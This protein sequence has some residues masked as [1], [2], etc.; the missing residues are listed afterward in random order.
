KIVQ[1]ELKSWKIFFGNDMPENEFAKIKEFKPDILV[2]VDAVCFV[3]TNLNDKSNICE[4][5][6]LSDEVSYF[7][8]AHN[9][10]TSVWIKYLR[11]FVPKILFLGI[12]VEMSN[13]IQI[14]ENL[15]QKAKENARLAVEKIKILD[16]E[17]L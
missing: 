14:K 10:P 2:V 9:I 3:D 12:S 17:L 4:F 8:N 6:D 15:S 1:K 11:E 13:L 5:I 16:S 7:Y